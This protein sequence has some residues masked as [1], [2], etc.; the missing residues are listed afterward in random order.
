MPDGWVVE[1]SYSRIMD[2][3]LSRI[4][5]MVWIN[6][7]FR[8]SFWRLLKRT[9]PRGIKQTQL[10]TE[11]GPHESL[12]QTFLS[13]QSILW[14]AITSHPS[15]TNRRRERIAALRPDVRAYELRSPREVEAFVR[16]VEAQARTAASRSSTQ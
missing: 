9:I 11:T 7:P 4:D 16:A 14:W 5:T 12:R 3:Y 10:Y 1:G 15:A 2:V 13:K 6:L 8:T